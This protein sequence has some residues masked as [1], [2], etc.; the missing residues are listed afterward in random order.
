MKKIE[1]EERVSKRRMSVCNWVTL[2]GAHLFAVG[3]AGTI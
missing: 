1:Q 3:A 2:A